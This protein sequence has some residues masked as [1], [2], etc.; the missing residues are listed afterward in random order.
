MKERLGN[1]FSKQTKFLGVNLTPEGPSE[2]KSLDQ[3]FSGQNLLTHK[4]E[5]VPIIFMCN[6]YI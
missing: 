3:T 2:A 5:T 6:K 4:I 1:L